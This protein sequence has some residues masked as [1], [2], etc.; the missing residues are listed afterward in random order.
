MEAHSSTAEQKRLFI[1][2]RRT[3]LRGTANITPGGKTGARSP[4]GALPGGSFFRTPRTPWACSPH[5]LGRRSRAS[6]AVAGNG[7]GWPRAVW[8]GMGV[9]VRRQNVLEHIY[10]VIV[11]EKQPQ[12]L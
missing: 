7:L 6:G 10:L 11:I 2:R 9:C 8:V 1:S 3:A 12:K 5:A 4:G